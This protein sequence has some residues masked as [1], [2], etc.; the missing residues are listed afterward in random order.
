MMLA[1][2]DMNLSKYICSG[3]VAH[4]QQLLAAAYVFACAVQGR[5][6]SKWKW[7]VLYNKRRKMHIRVKLHVVH[8]VEQKASSSLPSWPQSY[9]L[10][11][12]VWARVKRRLWRFM[13]RFIS[14]FLKSSGEFRGDPRG[15]SLGEILGDPPGEPALDLGMSW[16][17]GSLDTLRSC[18]LSSTSACSSSELSEHSSLMVNRGWSGV[19]KLVPLLVTLVRGAVFDLFLSGFL[20]KLYKTFSWHDIW[21][22]SVSSCGGS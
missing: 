19:R 1:Y 14:S 10:Y 20:N 2:W 6:R 5:C 16:M 3:L 13:L 7:F 18:G 11:L 12:G 22:W 9:G 8:S 17:M 15:E 4:P 21:Q